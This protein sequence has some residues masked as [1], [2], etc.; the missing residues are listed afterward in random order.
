MYRLHIQQEQKYMGLTEIL[1]VISLENNDDWL[2]NNR[3]W[4]KWTGLAEVGSLSYA[5]MDFHKPKDEE[6]LITEIKRRKKLNDNKLEDNRRQ[7]LQKRSIECPE[8]L[9]QVENNKK[10]KEWTD[11][12]PGTKMTY[13]GREYNEKDEHKLM[14]AI[15]AQ[16]KSHNNEQERKRFFLKELNV[17][18]ALEGR[19]G[20]VG[21]V[22]NKI[23]LVMAANTNESKE[24]NNND[25]ES[26][27]DGNDIAKKVADIMP[28]VDIEESV[29]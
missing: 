5:G 27:V 28:N 2:A 8:Q 15:I 25:S 16:M 11:L 14:K 7:V 9:K 24:N 18:E 4:K 13:K 22:S 20:N 21:D 6:Q 1:F 10:W 3:T 17:S 12:K 19:E 26:C 23:D 29:E